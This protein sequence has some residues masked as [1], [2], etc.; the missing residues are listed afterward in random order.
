MSHQTTPLGVR[1][2]ASVSFLAGGGAQDWDNLSP[3]ELAIFD[4]DLTAL[5]DYF[6][7]ARDLKT[8]FLED[9]D[10]YLWAASIAKKQLGTNFG[11]AAPASGQFG[12]QLIRPKTVLGTNDWLQSYSN[13]GWQNVFGSSGSPVDLSSTSTTYG[14]PQNRV[15]MIIANLYSTTIPK[16]REV[17]FH[18]GSTDYAIWPIEFR[19]TSDAWIAGLPAMPLITKNGKFYMRGNVGSPIGVVDGA[20]PLGLTFALAEYMTG[21]GQE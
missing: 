6:S 14:N 13:A 7:L 1:N 10:S 15:L 21:S 4:R 19:N 2:P 9:R 12:M 16:I 17:W 11:G 20:A 8:I 18:I 5:S 3:D